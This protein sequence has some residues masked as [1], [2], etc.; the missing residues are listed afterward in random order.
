MSSVSKQLVDSVPWARWTDSMFAY[1]IGGVAGSKKKKKKDKNNSDNED[2]DNKESS[3]SSKK[4]NGVDI[5]PVV[6]PMIEQIK[7]RENEL[8]ES[9]LPALSVMLI[10][11]NLR[12]LNSRTKMLS[13]FQY[14]LTKFLSWNDPAYTLTILSIYTYLCIYP[15]L[16][17]CVPIMGL[18][19][20]ILIP[21]YDKRHPAPDLSLEPLDRPKEPEFDEMSI[22]TPNLSPPEEFT[23]QDKDIISALKQLQEALTKIVKA[24]EDFDR[25]VYTTGSFVNEND[26]S[27]LFVILLA[28]L[29]GAIY[30][31]SFIPVNVFIIATGWAAVVGCHPQMQKRAKKFKE[32]YAEYFVQNEKWL[33]EMLSDFEKKEIIIDEPPE[34]R[35]VEIFELQRQ[36][37][38]PRQWDPWVFTPTI[39]SVNSPYRISQSR[40][41]GTRFVEDVLPPE[42]WHFVPEYPWELD[43]GT[44][45]WVHYR[46]IKKIEIDID[47]YWAYDSEGGI[48]GEWRRRRWTRKCFRQAAPPFKQGA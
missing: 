41:P 46:D 15:N 35:T 28:I 5:S 42:G 31:A 13:H 2:D 22:Y 30:G 32:D 45:S 11:S 44:K 36:G 6:D 34:E 10:I 23:K 24:L 8:S 21:G 1:A 27:A 7:K 25:F 18:L 26:S 20:G 39:Y 19:L 14:H 40:P 12:K 43:S 16:I 38:T 47:H 29:P 33:E 4:K 37:L 3:S 17:V 48:H 9:H